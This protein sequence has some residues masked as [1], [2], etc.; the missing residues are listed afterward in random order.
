[1]YFCSV[2]K[3]AEYVLADY[4]DFTDRLLEA[5]KAFEHASILLS[6]SYSDQYGKYELLAAFG[7]N[8]IVEKKENSFEELKKNILQQPKW[9]FGH[10]SYELKNEVEVLSS[11]HSAKFQFPNLFFFEP[12]FLFL[13]KRGEKKGQLYA[14]DDC[15]PKEILGFLD[16]AKQLAE[17]DR[18][19]FPA[20]T[21]KQTKASYLSAIKKVKQHIQL[22][23]IYEINYCQKF[24]AERVKLQPI[25]AFKV[26]NS[27]SP[28]PFATFYKLE[29]KFVMGASPERFMCKQ[30]N[31]L[32]S[33]PI[34]GTAK[35]GE[36]AVED[37]KIKEEL[38]YNLKEQTENVMIVDLVRNDLSRTAAKGSV[39]VEELF[40]VYTFPQVHQLISTI[41]SELSE[42]YHFVDAIEHSFPMGSMT[43]APKISA[44]KIADKLEKSNREIYSGS[45]G[46]ITPNGD[47][48]FNVVIRSLVYDAVTN[49]LSLSV[50]GAITDGSDPEK[51]Y[52]ECLLKA[53]AI[54]EPDIL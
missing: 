48:D 13:Q 17:N 26:L 31:Q 10:L 21:A 27:R 1:V 15:N 25:A 5:T 41:G 11:Q 30:G 40:G 3:I 33:Q 18:L 19:V 47:F 4:P 14:Q 20:F 49:Y 54:F 8:Q 50:G 35:R 24:F 12:C 7:A 39:K 42:K 6:N 32:V 34:K 44:M 16:S 53:K 2:K 43:G 28:M 23:D 22:G 38:K 36:T 9:L 51:E 37:E 29:N 45:I 52:E 46:Y